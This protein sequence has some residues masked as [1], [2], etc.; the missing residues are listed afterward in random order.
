MNQTMLNPRNIRYADALGAGALVYASATLQS[1]GWQGILNEPFY[2]FM[3]P[4][5]FLI[6]LFF[7]LRRAGREQRAEPQNRPL[8]RVLIFYAVVLLIFFGLPNT[9][10]RILI[11]VISLA[12]LFNW[13]SPLPK[14]NA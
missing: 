11:T 4:A 10:G 6:A 3:Y 5:W 13:K 9:A 1:H 14:R 8:I 12:N 7:S 2:L